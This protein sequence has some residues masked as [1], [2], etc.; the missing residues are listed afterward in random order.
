MNKLEEIL[1]EWEKDS[2][3]DAIDIGSEI[4]KV[5]RLHSKYLNILSHYRL[6]AKESEFKYSKLYLLKFQHQQ[7]QLD[8]TELKSLGWEPVLLNKVKTDVPRY[9]DADEDLIK[10]K[11]QIA[12]YNEIVNTCDF[13][14]K[15]I[16][17]RNYYL[18]AMVDWIKFTNG[19]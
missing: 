2:V 17:S 12:F 1:S 9:L 19:A 15:E 3:V 4:Q 11:S 6:K 16:N 5:P 7:G 18:K 14:M 8:L 10:L 13:I